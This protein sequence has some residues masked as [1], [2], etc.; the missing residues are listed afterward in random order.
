MDPAREKEFQTALLYSDIGRPGSG[1]ARFAAAMYFYND[2]RLSAP[3]LEIYRRCCN[4]DGE[5]PVDLARFEG[6]TGFPVTD[7]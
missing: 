7:A 2:G 1:A 3:M 6:L 5:D 4:L